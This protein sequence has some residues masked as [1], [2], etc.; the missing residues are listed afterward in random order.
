MR[1][2]FFLIFLLVFTG[3]K[4]QIND[5]FSD[6]DFTANPAWSGDAALF[7]VNTSKKLQLNASGSDT[8][9]LATPNALIN[10]TQ[11]SFYVKQSFNS[12]VNNHSRIYLVSDSQNLKGPLHGYFVQF[13]SSQDDICLYRQDSLTL[14]KI[15]AGTHGNT[16]NSTNTFTLKITRDTS[17]NWELFSDASAGNTFVSEG[18]AKDTTYKTTAWF[19]VFCKFT[20]SNSKKFYFDDF[21]VQKITI[22]TTPPVITAVTAVSASAL[23]VVFNEPVDDTSAAMTSNYLVDNGIGQPQSASRDAVNTNIVHLTFSQSFVLAKNYTLTAGGIKDPAGN[24]MNTATRSFYYYVPQAFDVV[25]NEIMAD[26]TP[27]VGLNGKEYIEIYNRSDFD[28]NLGGWTFTN[29]TTKTILPDSIIGKGEYI[30]LCKDDYIQDFS[31]YGKVIGL[32]SFSLVN[33]G[34]SL[35]LTGKNGGVIHNVSYS[36]K[37]YGQSSKAEGGW[38]LEQIDPDN[39]CGCASNWWASNDNKG[40]TPGKI[41]SVDAS[42][43]D[44]TAPRI[45]RITANDSANITVFFTEPMDSASILN[46]KAYFMTGGI[47]F[48]LSVTGHYPGYSSV[49]LNTATP[50]KQGEVYKLQIKDSLYDCT[51]NL[52][53]IN[54]T[55]RFGLARNVENNDVVINEILFN[56]KDNG[57]DFVEI[58][59]RSRKIIDLK[60]LRLCNYSPEIEDFEN[61]EEITEEGIA[62]FP[63]DYFVLTTDPA[64]VKKQYFTK[65]PD[66]FA[67]MNGFPVMSNSSGNIWLITKAHKVIDSI[68]YDE[69]MHY[70]LLRDVEGVSLERLNYD[71]PST[72]SNW[73]SAAETAGFATPA[74]INSQFSQSGDAPEDISVS[75][76]IFSPDNDGYDDVLN[77]N[78]KLNSGTNISKI[79][80][81][82][83]RGQ[84]VRTLSTSSFYGTEGVVTWDGTTDNGDKAPL[85]I[86]IIFVETLNLDGSVKTYKKSAT[87]GGRLGG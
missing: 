72:P 43:P 41:N 61:I 68:Y 23:D 46:P 45:L 49:K 75:P 28:I 22:D 73:H 65:S 32:S 70:P 71:L 21:L 47:D 37:W 1:L 36:V 55:V 53:T 57:V 67:A 34:S 59:N 5:D 20:S 54:T 63:G 31:Q 48:P 44:I 58:Y 38:S 35:I 84:V 42:N 6:G 29:K 14:T 10:G 66:N 39:P 51:G 16:G 27:V 78:Y 26:P 2:L 86:Y 81:Y 64:M 8:A 30:I 56:P 12:S 69:E 52:L 77:I 33:S 19:G 25:F 60:D 82:N 85:G 7:K 18:K 76:D 15:I 87:L 74:Y 9:F 4:A 79:I 13:G 3:L 17:G 83:T 11:W 62:L 80:I 40:G 24:V 50:L